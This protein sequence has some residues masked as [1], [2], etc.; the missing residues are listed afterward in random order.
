MITRRTLLRTGMGAT[1]GA[2]LWSGTA[3]AGPPRT[4]WERL[5]RHLSGDV[6]LPG[7]ATYAQARQ[8]DSAAF[9]DVLPRAIA[10]CENTGDVRT[11][12]RFAQDN[13]IAVAVRS[14]GHSA[15][16]YSTTTG[17][18]L[19]VSRLNQID[20]GHGSVR[21]GPGVQ[22][23]D[24]LATLSPHGL[25]AIT[26]NCPTVGMGGYLQGGGVGPLSRKY[27]VASDR[28]LSAEVVLA[29]GRLV[30]CS[31]WR[32]PELFWALRGGGGGNFGVVTRYEIA[33]VTTTRMVSFNLSWPYARAA[34]VIAAFL[35]WLAVAPDDL[36]ANLTVMNQNAAPGSQPSLFVSGSWFGGPVTTVDPQLG[37]LVSAVGSAPVNRSAD[38]LTY[39][40]AMMRMFGCGTKTVQQCHRVGY[41]PEATLPRQSF[42]L[43][44]GRLGG[45]PLTTSAI[46]EALAVYEADPAAGQFR[47]MSW[48]GLGGQ[49]NRVAPSATAYV[50]RGAQHYFTYTAGV[51]T[52]A[53]SGEVKASIGSWTAKGF[54][55][56]RRYGNGEG[57]VNFIDA[58]LPDWRRAYYGSNHPRLQ[59]AKRH[60]D[61]HGFLRFAQGL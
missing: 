53:P 31:P 40:D 37:E 1:A 19:D 36:T 32:E 18:V 30:R 20:V 51:R 10:Y 46:S 48:G 7:D 26:G 21:L 47:L 35:P 25:S 24:L 52:A 12:L 56:A 8:L 29:N 43:A 49:I 60:Y 38:D 2:L 54:E 33:P 50:H 3:T 4:R 23:V 22:G 58:A 5:R 27:G 28:L 45:R 57:Q 6:V 44:R 15:A 13:D 17:L 34:E 16:G 11:C 39:V 59:R 61:P 9:D 42:V 41:N 14:G 55:V